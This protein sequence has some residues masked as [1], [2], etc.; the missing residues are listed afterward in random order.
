MKKAFLK[1]A[2]LILSVC[3][4]FSCAAVAGA[5][6]S[7]SYKITNP[8][9]EVNSLIA[10][11]ENH[12]KTNLHT[13]STAS[14]ADV[15]FDDMIKAYYENGFDI[16]AMA[17]HGIIGKPWNEQPTRLPLYTYQYLL[18]NTVTKLTDEEYSAITGGTYAFSPDSGRTAGRGMQCLPGAIELN[19]LTM[20]KSHVNGYFTTAGE[21]DIGFE[22]GFEY[23]VKLTDKVGGISV[24]NHPG[25]WLGSSGDASI[26]RDPE[27]VRLFADI[28]RKYDSCVGMEIFN[29]IDSVDRNDRILWDEV[30]RAVV[31]EGERNVFGFS[32]SDAHVL[33]DIDTAFMD[34]ILPEYTLDTM[35]NAMENGHFFSIARIARNELGNDFKARGDYPRVTS[36]E[37]NEELDTITVKGI[38]CNKIQW[39]A[40]GDIIEETT[41][42]SDVV[43]STIKLRE[44]SDDISCYV[45]FQLL[46]EGGICCSQ[47]FICDDGNMERFIISDDR[48]DFEKFAD[49]V[50]YFLKSLRIYVAI[51]EIYREIF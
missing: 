31:P 28:M 27:N 11:P 13:H 51:Q 23:A 33:S 6:S 45:R 14:D 43:T 32:N 17:D 41:G 21:N 25:D 18:G 40:D 9:E 35:R 7:V 29:R 15:D 44:H 48:S 50:V 24:I 42:N 36:I 39:I 16:L 49:K 1:M 19:M 3:M 37:V 5:A 10:N 20:T 12:Y 34:F 22:N 46:G 8:Y 30:I 2:S 4:I 47:P 38:N 26:A